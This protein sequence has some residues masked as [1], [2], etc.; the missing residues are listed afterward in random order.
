MIKPLP[1][2]SACDNAGYGFSTLGLGCFDSVSVL[3]DLVKGYVQNPSAYSK[4]EN[5]LQLMTEINQAVYKL[6]ADGKDRTKGVHDINYL[7]ALLCFVSKQYDNVGLCDIHVDFI[8]DTV[9]YITGCKTRRL[10]ISSW[11]RLLTA[12]AN[13]QQRYSDLG[14]L[15]KR[16]DY[17]FETLSLLNEQH[18]PLLSMWHSQEGGFVD[19]LYT[20]NI[21]F[22]APLSGVHGVSVGKAG[23]QYISP[24]SWL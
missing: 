24:V 1:K 19:F 10:P 16:L 13:P 2:S 23:M 22:G 17:S 3:R 20:I 8:E 11:E 18:A 9:N 5:R 21:I 6:S 7:K 14:L 4:L 12:A 15:K